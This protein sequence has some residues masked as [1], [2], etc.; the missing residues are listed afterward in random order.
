MIIH[1]SGTVNNK[2]REKSEKQCKK[3][4]NASDNN[5][6]NVFSDIY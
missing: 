6:Y 5:I 4:E 1:Y 2:Q 3:S